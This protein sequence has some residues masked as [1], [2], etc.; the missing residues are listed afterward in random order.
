MRYLIILLITLFSFSAKG[1]QISTQ[2]SPNNLHIFK[3]GLQ[4]D[5]FIKVPTKDTTAFFGRTSD[6]I[7]Q[8]ATNKLM[9]RDENNN[10]KAIGSGS[11]GGGFI[12]WGD[13][14]SAI[15]TKSNLS[16]GIIITGTSTKTIKIT[17][18]NGTFISGTF[19]D[20]DNQTVAYNTTTK[21]FSISGGNSI[22]LP[23]PKEYGEL[24]QTIT[25]QTS[26]I[27]TLSQT[28]NPNKHF[29]ITMNNVFVNP[30]DYNFSGSTV[31][32]LFTPKPSDRFSFFYKSN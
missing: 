21:V 30:L 31:T 8:G 26:P 20:N 14:T 13:T 23:I 22:T 19:A 15:A 24:F 18:G 11:S 16:T 32:L 9:Y 1:Q 2:G 3:G 5:S 25:G 17:K 6:F 12:S 7:R 10:Y 28:I 27:F 29:Q 4:V